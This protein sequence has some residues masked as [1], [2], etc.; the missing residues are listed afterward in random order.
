MSEP[1]EGAYFNWLCAKAL[2]P[3]LRIYEDLLRI[4]YQTEFVWV[5]PGDHNRAEDGL[6]LREDFLRETGYEADEAW[7]GE[8][9]S[10]LEV[11]IGITRQLAFQTDIQAQEWFLRLLTNLGLDDYRRIAHSDVPVIEEALNT[12]VWRL[13]D[14]N[15]H[16]GIF[17]VRRA[18]ADQ[19]RAELW[20]QMFEYLDD[21]GL[22]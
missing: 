18:R 15:G 16:G 20:H 3:N 8:P 9:V 5:V 12:F 13:Y 17:P 2:L 19:R 11:L 7:F 1:L 22:L 4:L 21:Q 6:E 10:V 14:H